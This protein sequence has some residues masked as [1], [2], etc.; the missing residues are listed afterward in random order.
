MTKAEA[1]FLGVVIIILLFGF[2]SPSYTDHRRSTRSG[3]SWAFR[4]D[5]G[6]ES[7]PSHSSDST[8]HCNVGDGGGDCGGGDGGGFDGGG[9][10]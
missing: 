1:I 4:G 8:S 5:R 10:H 9:G 3:G 6:G 7:G 2:L